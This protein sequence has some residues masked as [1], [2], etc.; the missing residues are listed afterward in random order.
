[1]HTLGSDALLCLDM[2]GI[3][4]HVDIRPKY[5]HHT[6]QHTNYLIW[7]GKAIAYLKGCAIVNDDMHQ[8]ESM[9]A[10][11]I[12]CLTYV[13]VGKRDGIPCAKRANRLACEEVPG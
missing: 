4:A 5:T 6:H 9:A 7:N 3:N 2:K 12:L 10:T 13:V 11:E 8:V 1:M